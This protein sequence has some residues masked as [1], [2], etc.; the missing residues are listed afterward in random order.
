MSPELLD[1]ERFGLKDGRPTKESDIY[2][3]GMVVYEVLRGQL[4]FPECNAAVVI[5]KV[6]DGERPGRPEGSQ[7]AWFT[8]ELWEMLER[9]WKPQRGSRPSLGALLNCLKGVVP[10]SQPPS[11]ILTASD[12]GTESDDALVSAV[13]NADV[14]PIS[15]E[16]RRSAFNHPQ[17]MIGRTVKLGGGQLMVP[18]INTPRDAMHTILGGEGQLLF[19][20]N[21]WELVLLT[22]MV[23]CEENQWRM[24]LALPTCEPS[25]S[26]LLRQIAR[27][28]GS[29]LPEMNQMLNSTFKAQDYQ[30]HIKDL[31]GQDIDPQL[32]INGLDQ[33]DLCSAP[34]WEIWLIMIRRQIIN[35]LPLDTDIRKCSIRALKKT[36]MFYRLL[37][38][39]YAVASRISQPGPDSQ[40]SA[41]GE[42]SDVWKLIN[43]CGRALAVK[44]LRPGHHAQ[45][46]EELNKVCYMRL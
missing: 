17:D 22:G 23:D 5:R 4:P 40:P 43:E 1:P 7:G 9:C 46:T 24:A 18:P 20:I 11:P 6:M 35:I 29:S 34:V 16:P 32:Y 36:C 37:P 42:F 8:D 31:R 33:V 25:T 44:S 3:L 13:A 19:N 41:S 2:A 10:P 14:F 30:D 27:W 26:A 39:R 38:A 12:D 15:P 45:S 21:N 28:D